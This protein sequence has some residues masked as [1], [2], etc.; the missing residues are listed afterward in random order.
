[1]DNRDPRLDGSMPYSDGVIFDESDII[2]VS[3]TFDSRG[4]RDTYSAYAELYIPLVG[5][6]NE[7]ALIRAFEIQLAAR[8]ENPNDF[9]STTKPK[10][11]FR[12][13]PFSGFSLRT[14]YTEG[15]RAPNLLQLN[16]G[17]IVR[18][19]QG[20]EDPL[21]EDV[22]GSAL[23]SGDTYRYTTRQANPDLQPEDAETTMFGFI[24]APTDGF[25][26]G[27]RIGMDWWNIQTESA[28]GII[29]NDDQMELD[30]LLRSQGSFNPAVIRASVTPADQA[31]FDEWNAAN[32]DDQRTAVGEATNIITRYDNLDPRE[33]EGWDAMIEFA[34]GDTGAGQFRI[35]G[36]Y[37]KLTK[38]EQQGLATSDLLRRNGNP[39]DRYT[40]T[41]NWRLGSFSTNLSMRHIGEFYDSSLTQSTSIEGPGIV[42]GSTKYW[43]VEP[44]T[45]YNISARFDFGERDDAT[46]GLALTAGI[47]NLTDEDPPFADESFGYRRQLH[48]S[49][50]RV[51]WARVD[52]EF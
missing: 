49:Y 4:S 43:R 20:I 47:R 30:A 36:D 40:V 5:E 13:E 21:R 48:N 2:G 16:Q 14:S 24:Y 8:Y 1:V 52:Y 37:T 23:D 10:V 11:G 35:R 27:F 17:T 42:V 46:G 18:R 31:L 51:F 39:E 22:T 7:M 34:T 28:V 25:L 45:V 6:A 26:E 50:G 3:A 44:W 33:L 29:D 15:F 12:W 9:D 19:L 41:L 32:P 38:Y